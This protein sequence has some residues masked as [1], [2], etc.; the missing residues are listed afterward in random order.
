[1]EIDIVCS[2]LSSNGWYVPQIILEL[3]EECRLWGGIFKA[4]GRAS[5]WRVHVKF[6]NFPIRI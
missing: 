3:L 2:E 6:K 4:V 5:D 1:M